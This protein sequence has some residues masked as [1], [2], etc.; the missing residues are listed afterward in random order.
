[1]VT[2]HPFRQ[3]M[4]QA[5][6]QQNHLLGFPLPL[7]TFDQPPKT[8]THTVT[9]GPPPLLAGPHP[10]IQEARSTTD[11]LGAFSTVS[12]GARYA[13]DPAQAPDTTPTSPAT[14]QSQHAWNIRGYRD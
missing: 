8:M 1:M 13:R 6:Q 4:G 9:H 2:I 11:H 7:A 10:V 5:R 3:M 14:L 12:L